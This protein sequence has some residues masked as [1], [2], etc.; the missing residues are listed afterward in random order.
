M[1]LVRL[2]EI[3][4]VNPPVTHVTNPKSPCLYFAQGAK[5]LKSLPHVKKLFRHRLAEFAEKQ[6]L[7]CNQH[8]RAGHLN[9]CSY[10]DSALDLG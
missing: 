2:F 4:P 10:P 5:I 7:F 6:G 1:N 9:G 8:H 3:P